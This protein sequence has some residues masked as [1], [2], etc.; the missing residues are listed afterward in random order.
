MPDLHEYSSSI[1]NR[2]PTALLVSERNYSS[3]DR[4]P[5]ALLDFFGIPWASVAVDEVV[6]GGVMPVAG[7]T[8]ILT[9]ATHLAAI[10]QSDQN[11]RGSLP[12]WMRE[13]RSVYVYDFQ[14]TIA[15]QN[16]FRFLIDDG[17]G[18]IRNPHTS[19]T[20]VS[21][22]PDFAEMCGPLSGMR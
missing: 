18:N 19:H 10:L 21:V 15:C 9:S 16:L 1:T 2:L 22:T 8:S 5:A 14:D 3:A 13:A 7:A 17:Q 12:P 11:T 4:N 6:R 20:S